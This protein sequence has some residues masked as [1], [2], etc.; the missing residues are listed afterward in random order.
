[1][2]RLPTI[3]EASSDDLVPKRFVDFGMEKLVRIGGDG[4]NEDALVGVKTAKPEFPPLD[5]SLL[6]DL[7]KVPRSYTSGGRD[8]LGLDI[9][10]RKANNRVLYLRQSRYHH[11]YNRSAGRAP[12][13]S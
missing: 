11:E 6:V 2:Y 5:L 13:D 4:D 9:Y 7:G 3:A 1:V 10:I 8:L 12:E